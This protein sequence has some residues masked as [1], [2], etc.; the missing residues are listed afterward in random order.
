[1]EPSRWS[2][3]WY[4]LIRETLLRPGVR[5]MVAADERAPEMVL[6]YVVATPEVLH[7]AYTR[8]VERRQGHLRR[9][10]PHVLRELHGALVSCW[11]Q[12]VATW[13]LE[14]YCW[15][16]TPLYMLHPEEAHGRTEQLDRNTGT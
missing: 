10:W 5:V 2:A 4:P 12:D 8:K 1:M 16:Y 15:R 13:A 11:T 9:L 7:M 6:S 3:Y 14:R